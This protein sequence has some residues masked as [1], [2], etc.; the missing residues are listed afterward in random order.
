MAGNS[1]RLETARAH[2]ALRSSVSIIGLSL[3]LTCAL[4]ACGVQQQD[5]V[6]A[7]TVSIR[8]ELRLNAT[9]EDFS[10]LGRI[11]VGAHGEIIIGFPQDGHFR[12]YDSTGKRIATAGRK[13]QAPG[14]FQ[15]VG[16]LG[17]KADTIWAED[18]ESRRRNYFTPAGVFLR[19]ENPLPG[20]LSKASF[21]TPSQGFRFIIAAA[22][23]P[24]GSMLASGQPVQPAG[25]RG[26][27]RGRTFLSIDTSGKIRELVQGP[28]SEDPRWMMQTAQLG[29]PIPFA[30]WPHTTFTRDGS[31]FAFV[32]TEMDDAGGKYKV[33]VFRSNGDTVFIREYPFIGTVIPQS[34]RDSAANAEIRDDGSPSEGPSDLDQR[35]KRMALEKMP[36]I[37]APLQGVLLG[38]DNTT[39]LVLRDSA[40][41]RRYIVLDSVGTQLGVITLSTRNRIRQAT[42]THIWVTELDDADLASIVRYRVRGLLRERR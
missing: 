15:F 31:R 42:A 22:V 38:N 32:E 27:S 35:F 11:I 2:S 13:G 30:G 16:N 37:Y 1:R 14:E 3:L 19:T 18:A 17:L 29:R 33:S 5:S 10:V 21:L 34:E 20:E 26:P 25:S 41:L 24:D 23:H 36:R 9:A 28:S 8:E 12:I 4:A 40:Q 7:D 39:W 6:V